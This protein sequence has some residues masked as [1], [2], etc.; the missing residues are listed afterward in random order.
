MVITKEILNTKC[1]KG[2]RY[3]FD[4]KDINDIKYLLN[5]I[6]F[7]EITFN[8]DKITHK[9]I[10][11]DT[12]CVEKIKKNKIKTTHKESPFKSIIEDINRG[13]IMLRK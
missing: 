10:K 4:E 2:I 7:N 9:D 5:E 3:L 12:Y 11:I 1:I 6:A 8:E 13:L